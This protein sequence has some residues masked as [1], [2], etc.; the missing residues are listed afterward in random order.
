ML[1]A[2]AP[3]VLLF[4]IGL[5]TALGS[6][7]EGGMS[8]WGYVLLAGTTLVAGSVLLAAFVHFALASAGDEEI[9]GMR[10]S[11]NRSVNPP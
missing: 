10:R 7:R 5:A 8:S 4:G 11:A 3:F 9:S 1:A 6:R 2:A